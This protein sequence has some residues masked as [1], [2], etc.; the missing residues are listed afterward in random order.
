MESTAKSSS[1][2]YGLYLGII[3][4]LSIIIPYAVNTDI[5]V[6]PIYGI[7]LLLIILIIPIIASIKAKKLSGGIL[8]FKH[9]FTAFFLTL[10]IGLAI[11]SLTNYVLFNFIDLETGQAIQEKAIEARAQGMQSFGANEETISEFMNTAEENYQYSLSNILIGLAGSIVIFSI[12]GL[13]S[14]AFIKKNPENDY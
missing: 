6:N 1:I 4:A 11:S 12:L 5:L 8:N 9:T 13:I 7:S 3:L 2:N 10:V 14:S